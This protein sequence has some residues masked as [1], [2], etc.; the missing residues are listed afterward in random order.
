MALAAKGVSVTPSLRSTL[1]ELTGLRGRGCA[2]KIEY[3]TLSGARHALAQLR[4]VSRR[5]DGLCVYTCK[6]CGHYHV[7]H[8]DHTTEFFD[9]IKGGQLKGSLK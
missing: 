9:E 8:T 6:T 1:A 4:R 2:G 5:P 7:G 3:L